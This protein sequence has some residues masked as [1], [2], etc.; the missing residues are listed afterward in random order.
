M[1][2]VKSALQSLAEKGKVTHSFTIKD[3]KF[4]M[5]SLTT[6]EQILSDGLVDIDTLKKKYD[7]K[8]RIS[9][10]PDMIAKYRS[11]AQIAFAIKKINNEPPVDTE[12]TYSE[13][14]IARLEFRDELSQL[15]PVMLDEIIK[16]YKKLG[17]KQRDFYDNFE[18]NVGKSS[19]T[20]SGE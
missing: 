18:E 17:S 6:E 10:Y 13:Q 8:Q 15:D 19:I 16:E 5:E 9:T 11:L 7:T 1:S 4:E 14:F 3:T 12:K 20:Q 2:L